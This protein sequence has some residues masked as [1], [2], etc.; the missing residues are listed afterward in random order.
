[1]REREMEKRVREREG[2]RRTRERLAEYELGYARERSGKDKE[3]TG[4][5]REVLGGEAFE[6]FKKCE[7]YFFRDRVLLNVCIV[8]TCADSTR[9]L[10]HSRDRQGYLDMWNVCW[11]RRPRATSVRPR[12]ASCWMIW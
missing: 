12:S 5:F 6:A 8:Q 4:R 7:F 11:T 10:F 2:A 3:V 9:K 1:M